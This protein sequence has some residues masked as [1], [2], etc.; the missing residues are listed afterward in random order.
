MILF[1]D[2]LTSVSERRRRWMPGGAK[3]DRSAEALAEA[4]I[5][6]SGEMSGMAITANILD[7]FEAIDDAGKLAFFHHVAEQMTGR[8]DAL[9]QALEEFESGQTKAS[10][11]ALMAAAAPPRQELVRRVNQAPGAT[12][13]LVRMRA[14]FLRLGHDDD[15]LMVLDLDF[16]HLFAN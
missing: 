1:A 13:R 12:E 10:Y 11:L 4:L 15:D 14:H 8:P 7:T 3:D 9:R 5:D 2:L 6:G 16:R